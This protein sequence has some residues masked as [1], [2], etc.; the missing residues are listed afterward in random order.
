MDGGSEEARPSGGHQK[1]GTESGDR[2][3]LEPAQKQDH[4]NRRISVSIL[5]GMEPRRIQSRAFSKVISTVFKTESFHADALAKALR[6]SKTGTIA[7]LKRALG[8]EVD[9]TVFRKLKQ[10]ACRTSYSPVV[11]CVIELSYSRRKSTSM[12]MRTFTGWPSFIAGLNFH[13]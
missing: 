8:T 5:F 2:G 10:V 11:F 12:L 13:F 7:E 1:Q 9:V 4:I 6:H 3:C